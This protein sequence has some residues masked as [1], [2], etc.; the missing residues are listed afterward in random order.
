MLCVIISSLFNHLLYYT[1]NENI[2]IKVHHSTIMY[3]VTKESCSASS[4][5][6]WTIC[7]YISNGTTIGRVLILYPFTTSL[8]LLSIK[9]KF[10]PLSGIGAARSTCKRTSIT[11]SGLGATSSCVFLC[12]PVTVPELFLNVEPHRRICAR[13]ASSTS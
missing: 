6:S 2:S 8:Y 5:C 12:N 1:S 13:T 3:L 7:S 4:T 11:N 10:K 9:S